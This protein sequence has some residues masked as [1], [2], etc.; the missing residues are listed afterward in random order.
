MAR[1]IQFPAPKRPPPQ[2]RPAKPAPLLIPPRQPS[3]P[4]QKS[5]ALGF[6]SNML[7]FTIGA[8]VGIPL[9]FF[10]VLVVRPA[11]Y[12]LTA[13]VMFDVLIQLLR[14]LFIGG[15]AI[16]TGLAH[17]AVIGAVGGLVAWI[18]QSLS[19]WLDR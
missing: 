18:G 2:A 6:F 8:I 5:T 12:L 9:V 14:M 3:R 16:L 15:P 13:V 17:F 7:L 10:F 1:I 19:R 4:A 11:F